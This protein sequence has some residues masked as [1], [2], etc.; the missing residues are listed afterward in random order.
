M[1][2]ELGKASGSGCLRIYIFEKQAPSLHLTILIVEAVITY[3][4]TRITQLLQHSQSTIPG[5]LR[6][7]NHSSCGLVWSLIC[8]SR[9][10]IFKRAGEEGATEQGPTTHNWKQNQFSKKVCKKNREKKKNM[11]LGQMVCMLSST[12]R[13]WEH[14][15]AFHRNAGGRRPL[16]TWHPRLQLK[17]RTWGE[18][19]SSVSLMKFSGWNTHLKSYLKYFYAG[20]CEG[21]ST[22]ITRV[23]K[24]IP[25]PLEVF[26]FTL[27]F[28]R[29][30]I[31]IWEPHV[32]P[33]RFC[34][35]CCGNK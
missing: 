22:K 13:S 21:S 11:G 1:R 9:Q 17:R 33:Y 23:S 10:D 4:C 18:F 6:N 30:H 12:S 5:Y 25:H 31:C 8:H 19:S 7:F 32:H 35:L 20:G 27:L 28:P 34:G 24:K 16:L 29:P 3:G 14:V 2:G 15:E 26:H